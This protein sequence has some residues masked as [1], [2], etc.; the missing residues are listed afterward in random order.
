M[1]HG[2]PPPPHT[3][4]SHSFCHKGN[5]GPQEVTGPCL[6]SLGTFGARHFVLP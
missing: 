3:G 2:V 6:P 5:R 1:Y 4:Q